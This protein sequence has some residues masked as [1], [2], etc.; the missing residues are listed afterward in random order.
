MMVTMMRLLDRHERLDLWIGNNFNI[1][2]TFINR[3]DFDNNTLLSKDIYNG[4]CDI[5]DRQL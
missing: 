1:K 4:T 5:L 2:A 3:L